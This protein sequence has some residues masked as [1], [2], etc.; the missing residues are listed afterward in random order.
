MVDPLVDRG[1]HAFAVFGYLDTAADTQFVRVSRLQS[2]SAFSDAGAPSPN[3]LSTD[4]ETGVKTA[5]SDSLVTLADG[6]SGLVYYAAFDVRPGSQYLLEVSDESEKPTRA[7]T[8]VPES[9]GLIAGTPRRNFMD[10]L[11]QT[12]VWSGLPRGREAVVHYRL[13]TIPSGA[14]TTV[15]ITYRDGGDVHSS[16]WIVNVTLERDFRVVRNLIRSARGD[17]AIALLDVSMSI[18]ATS[19]EW[20]QSEASN[21][22]NGTGFFA[23][24]A[25]LRESWS[26]DSTI[27]RSIGFELP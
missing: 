10:D 19:E 24:V 14:D 2:E 16:G 6:S 25:R 20:S 9:I 17:T 7:T 11:E 21:I 18:E 26:L 8:S 5:W 12:V 27:V 3:V 15:A 23:S 13:R 1:A 4:L 22:E